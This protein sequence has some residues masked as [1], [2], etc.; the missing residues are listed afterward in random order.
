MLDRS[1]STQELDPTL[2]DWRALIYYRLYFRDNAWIIIRQFPNPG[3]RYRT[4]SWLPAK[5]QPLFI[6]P[7]DPHP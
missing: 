1:V 4:G 5:I 2:L 6:T 7:F 3:T